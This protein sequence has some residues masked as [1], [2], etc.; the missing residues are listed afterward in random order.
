[1]ACIV[2]TILIWRVKVSTVF[3]SSCRHETRLICYGGI[4]RSLTTAFAYA[5]ILQLLGGFTF[6]VFVAVAGESELTSQRLFSTLALL[7][8]LRRVG[9]AFL[10]TSIF[11]T[12][13][14]N[15]AVQRI[16][17]REAYSC[18]FCINS[19]SEPWACKCMHV[20]CV[21]ILQKFLLFEEVASTPFRKKSLGV[22]GIIGW[23]ALM[24]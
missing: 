7:F 2:K 17:V 10:V 3:H 23:S 14:A 1:M 24:C 4:I 11:S 22:N 8:L 20:C 9:G 21:C 16:Q 13:E 5:G 18:T 6:I 15:V 19:D 12:Y